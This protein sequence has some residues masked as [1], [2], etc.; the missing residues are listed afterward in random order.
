ME[1]QNRNRGTHDRIPQPIRSDGAGGP[2]YG[3]RDVM[4]D[5]ENPDMLVPPATDAGLMPNLKMSFSD[6]HMQ[7][8][9]GGWSREITVRD[10]P[11]A[12]T[13]AG[14]NMSLTPGGVRELHWHQQAEWAYMIWG[15]ARIT[16]MDASGRNFIADVGPG[17]LWYFPAGLPHS[18]QGL[19]EGCEF[20]LVFDD[21]HFSDLNTLSISDWFAHTPKD[22]LSANFGVPE[23]AFD[24][25]PKEQVY[26]FQDQ[27]PGSLESQKVQSPYGTVPLSFKHRLLAQEPIITP[28]GSVR[29]VDSSN[30]PISK[31]V[32]AALVEI[33]PGAMRELHWHPNQDEWQ[34]YLA[35]QGRMTVFAGNGAARTFD[36]RAGD[37]GY[38]PFAFGHY[39][40][41]TGTESL[42]FLEMFRSDRFED[43]SLNQWMALTPRD[44]VQDNLRVGTEVTDALRKEKWPVVKYPGY[45]YYPR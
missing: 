10:L 17:D 6:T 1:D 44:L 43:V 38:V 31:T 15:S 28:G 22:V 21:G 29:I 12:T 8:N 24:H 37:V 19:E 27:V 42:W 3:P 36:Y 2:D 13:L 34:Y 25:I 32:A 11:V 20:L 39:I 16:A 35:G 9:H 33:K 4:R 30:F 41:N 40:Q 5:I 14:V 26:I 23:N 18:I 45:S 7:L